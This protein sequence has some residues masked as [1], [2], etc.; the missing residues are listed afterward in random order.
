MTDLNIEISIPSDKDGFCLMQ[1]PL[2]GGFFKLKPQDIEAEDMIRIWCPN[3]GFESQNYFTEDVIEL[4]LAKTENMHT[5]AIFDSF[6]KLKRQNRNKNVSVKVNKPSHKHENPIIAGIE[7][8]DIQKYN[9][10]QREAKIKPIVKLIGSYCP[11]CGVNDDGN[12]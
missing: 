2:C 12:H 6:N 5:D 9:C 7:L 1:C 4:A 8:L 10:C 11:F 3:C